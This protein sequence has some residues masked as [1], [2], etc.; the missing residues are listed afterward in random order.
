MNLD[1]NFAARES[2]YGPNVENWDDSVMIDWHEPRNAWMPPRCTPLVVQLSLL[3]GGVGRLPLDKSFAKPTSV[4]HDLPGFHSHAGEAWKCNL[5][6]MRFTGMALHKIHSKPEPTRI[7][8]T[9]GSQ[10]GSNEAIFKRLV[11]LIET[12]STVVLG[13]GFINAVKPEHLNKFFADL[14]LSWK[15]GDK[16][17]E[18]QIHRGAALDDR[19]KAGARFLDSMIARTCLLRD[20]D[21]ADVWYSSEP[22]SE[23]EVS[24]AFANI[25][26]GHL[27]FVGD[28][29]GEKATRDVVKAML[30]A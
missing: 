3:P 17:G 9:H 28:I 7:V 12:G 6:I 25:K 8:L 23:G 14:G 19:V 20:V 27:G 13:G 24:V 22:L 16:C 5:E 18:I 4:W 26:K 30:W 29:D 10:G 2:L 21:L 11:E 1:A 15:I